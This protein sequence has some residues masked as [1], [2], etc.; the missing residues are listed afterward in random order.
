MSKGIA[1]VGAV[2]TKAQEQSSSPRPAPRLV[3]GPAL[4]GLQAL[5][6][7]LARFSFAEGDPCRTRSAAANGHTHRRTMT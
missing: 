6:A 5:S 4:E 1:T 2:I 3:T 7:V